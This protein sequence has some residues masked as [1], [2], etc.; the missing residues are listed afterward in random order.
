MGKRRRFE[1]LKRGGYHSPARLY[2]A[3]SKHRPQCF[4]ATS[5]VHVLSGILAWYM[6]TIA[7][8]LFHAKGNDSLCV[9]GSH[10]AHTPEAFALTNQEIDRGKGI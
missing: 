5:K 4:D 7:L 2:I 6:V 3:D 8:H 10:H 1:R 9:A